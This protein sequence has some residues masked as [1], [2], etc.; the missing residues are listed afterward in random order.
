MHQHYRYTTLLM[1]FLVSGERRWA[2]HTVNQCDWISYVPYLEWF[3]N[4]LSSKIQGCGDGHVDHIAI[5]ELS[6]SY[7]CVIMVQSMVVK[8]T[9]STKRILHY[10][11]V[12]HKHFTLPVSRFLTRSD[13]TTFQV[14]SDPRR[15][16]HLTRKSRPAG[17]RERAQG[18][19]RR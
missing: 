9:Q 13:P 15:Q 19:S 2:G 16:A 1:V 18:P 8:Y 3:V 7:T 10:V 6:A 5:L 14:P 17:N 11:F 4:S 12:T